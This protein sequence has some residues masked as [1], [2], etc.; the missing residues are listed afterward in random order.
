[1]AYTKEE[2][3]NRAKTVSGPN[4]LHTK[5]KDY[6]FNRVLYVE[7]YFKFFDKVDDVAHEW[8]ERTGLVLEFDEYRKVFQKVLTEGCSCDN[9]HLF[10]KIP[11][12]HFSAKIVL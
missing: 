4:M 5:N 1:M 2:L 7:D 10:Y 12:E 8:E 11:S 6:I 3:M 9:H